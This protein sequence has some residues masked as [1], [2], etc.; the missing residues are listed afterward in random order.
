LG[1]GAELVPCRWRRWRIITTPIEIAAKTAIT[2]RIGTRGEE[3]LSLDVLCA[4]A[5]C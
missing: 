5:G 4:P 2:R 3:E 1:E